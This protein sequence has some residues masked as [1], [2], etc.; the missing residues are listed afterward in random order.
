MKDLKIIGGLLLLMGV[1][2]IIGSLYLSYNIFSAKTLVPEIFKTEAI[3]QSL[4]VDSP[5][6][7]L[8]AVFQEQIQEQLKGLLPTDTI[9]KLLNLISWSIFSGIMMFAGGQ[10]SNLGIKLM[11]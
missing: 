11:R 10:I 3:K 9:P 7:Q 8:E 1:T 2:I 4:Q 6:N 5:A